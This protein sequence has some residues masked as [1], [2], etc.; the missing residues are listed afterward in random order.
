MSDKK[1][2]IHIVMND[3]SKIENSLLIGKVVYQ[4]DPNKFIEKKYKDLTLQIQEAVANK[5]FTSKASETDINDISDSEI[6]NLF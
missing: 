3:H 4:Y 2:G 6:I 5:E 1:D